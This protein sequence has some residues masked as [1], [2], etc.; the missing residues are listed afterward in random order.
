MSQLTLNQPS[1]QRA[2]E[3]EDTGYVGCLTDHQTTQ[4]AKFVLLI[5]EVFKGKGLATQDGALKSVLDKVDSSD[6]GGIYQFSKK[7]LYEE[8]WRSGGGVSPDAMLLRFLRAR[9]FNL[10]KALIM[11]LNT[12]CWRLHYDVQKV[13]EEGEKNLSSTHFNGRN[14]HFGFDKVGRPVSYIHAKHHVRGEQSVQQMEHFTLYMIETGRLLMKAPVEKVTLVFDLSGLT[15]K[16]LDFQLIQFL[17]TTLQSYYPESLGC[18]LIVSAPFLFQGAWK[19]IKG[20]LDPV[21]QAKVVFCKPSELS[22][23]IDPMYLAFP[24]HPSKDEGYRFDLQQS[25][26][27]ITKD[28]DPNEKN[29]LFYQF[30]MECER[31][32]AINVTWA[33]HWLRDASKQ[34]SLG[35]FEIFQGF[36]LS[37]FE[38]VDID[39]NSL[40]SV[41]NAYFK[42]KVLPRFRAFDSYTRSPS[43]WHR[44]GVITGPE[45]EV[46]WNVL[47]KSK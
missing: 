7:Q 41:R 6:K 25:P 5:H 13:L 24:F 21:V 45:N 30:I 31:W 44:C 43:W 4:L 9:K 2:T 42:N 29:N 39:L 19:V 46:N 8:L 33:Q 28:V 27:P 17:V 40:V 38:E 32:D 26:P 16:N 34:P 10:E 1:V 18:C 37:A 23:Y 11:L 12:L 22:T 20:W 15:L 47:L 3:L 36:K 14:Y 35:E